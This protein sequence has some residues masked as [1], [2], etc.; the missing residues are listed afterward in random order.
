MDERRGW[1]ADGKIS[2]EEFLESTLKHSNAEEEEPA[3]A[4]TEWCRRNFMKSYTLEL[5]RS[6]LKYWKID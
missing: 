4:A 2:I 3:Q 1:N 5:S 6:I